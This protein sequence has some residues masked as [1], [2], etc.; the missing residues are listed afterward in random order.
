M[1]FI[2][3]ISFI[4]NKTNIQFAL[5]LEG[6]IIQTTMSCMHMQGLILMEIRGKLE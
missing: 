3:G 1:L 2:I 4:K 6:E 5:N